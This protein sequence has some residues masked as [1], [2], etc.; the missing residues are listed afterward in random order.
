MW[1]Q[2][3]SDSIRR[4]AVTGASG[5]IGRGLVARLEREESIERMLAI[6]VRPPDRAPSSKVTFLLRDVAEPM[7][8]LLSEHEIEAVVHLAFLLKPGHSRLARQRV[9][10]EGTGNVFEACAKVG[11]R[12]IVYLSS[13]T[14]YGAHPDNPPLLIEDSPVRPVKGFPYSEDKVRAELMLVDLGSRYPSLTSTILRAC[15]VMGPSADNFIARAFSRPFLVSVQGFDPPMQLLHEDDLTEVICRCLLRGVAGTYNVAGEG[16]IPWSQMASTF[17]RR[18][19]R[20]PAPLL[21]P[22]TAAA[23]SL[24]LQGDSPACGLDFIR[25]RWTVSTEKIQRELGFSFKHSAEDA[26]GA[27]AERERD[28]VGAR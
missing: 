10:I 25:Y 4:V 3:S 28:S 5:Y 26:W 20:V 18:L 6:D 21:Y 2:V 23:W 14:V 16:G 9:N 19:V 24:R 11:V 17:G 8:R 15:P 27:F 7:A 13:T 12:H 22:L 1:S